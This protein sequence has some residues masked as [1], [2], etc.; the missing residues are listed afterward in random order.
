MYRLFKAQLRAVLPNPYPGSSVADRS[1]APRRD[2]GRP[3][4]ASQPCAREPHPAPAARGAAA[5]D[6]SPSS[7]APAPELVAASGAA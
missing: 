7:S 1:S 6:G 2:D 5:L 3:A 4:A